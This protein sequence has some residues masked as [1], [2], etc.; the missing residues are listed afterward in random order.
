MR[1]IISIVFLT[2]CNNVIDPAYYNQCRS[3]CDRAAN[4]C[5]DIV[6][7]DCISSCTGFPTEEEIISFEVCADCY[8]A[9][10]CDPRGYQYVCY[11]D[12][13]L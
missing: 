12:C 2:G 9:V 4:S 1:Y 8:I 5:N 7:E 10:N 6:M 11:P 3:I 13:E